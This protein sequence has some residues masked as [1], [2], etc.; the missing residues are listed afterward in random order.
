MNTDR[1]AD[2]PLDGNAAAGLLRELFAPDMTVAELTCGGCGAVAAL[3]A[4]PAFGGTMGAIL[5]CG[6]CDTAM[7]R[8]THTRAGLWLD[9]RGA[10]VL[11]A[12][13]ADS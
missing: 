8:L 5:R 4:V 1:Q 3:G 6:H 10:R 7:L 12:A 11:F 9:M 13:A 2:L